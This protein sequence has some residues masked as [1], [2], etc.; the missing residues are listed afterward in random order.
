[1]ESWNHHQK[2]CDFLQSFHFDSIVLGSQQFNSYHFLKFDNLRTTPVTD[3]HIAPQLTTC[4][5]VNEYFVGL[6]KLVHHLYNN[7]IRNE[8]NKWQMAMP[9][10]P[11]YQQ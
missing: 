8:D 1:M 11:R 9:P 5:K 3:T 2:L 10:W 6:F 7:T 4:S